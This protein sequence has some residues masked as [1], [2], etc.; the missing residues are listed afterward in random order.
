[1]RISIYSVLTFS[2]LLAGCIAA[3]GSIQE[4]GER[5]ENLENKVAAISSDL[6]D[7]Q[8]RLEIQGARIRSL[9]QNYSDMYMKMD[10][11]QQKQA[12]SA[13]S[14]SA[15]GEGAKVPST[16]D[17]YQ[18][19]NTLYNEGQYLNAILAYQ[20][21]IDTYPNDGKVAD[22]YLKQGLS[23]VKIGRTDGA[24]FFFKT[25]IDRFPESR[26]AAIAKQELEKINPK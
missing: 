17:L 15:A 3:P 20:V 25:L 11:L 21:F 16:G 8:R 4:L 1:M 5:Q 19:A 14:K 6:N 18:R 7:V 2:C 26:E 22:A 13:P 9:E 24:K 23:L 12:V 10:D